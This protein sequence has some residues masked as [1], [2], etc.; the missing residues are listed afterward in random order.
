MDVFDFD[1]ISNRTVGS[2]AR[3]RITDCP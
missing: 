1:I 3:D 2:E